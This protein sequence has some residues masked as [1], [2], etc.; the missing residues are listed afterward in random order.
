MKVKLSNVH[1]NPH[2][3]IGEYPIR[4]EKITFLMES[5]TSTTFWD[6]IVA[7]EHPRNSGKVEIAYGHHRLE[8]LRRL[9]EPDR[10]IEL[11]I[12]EID[13]AMML[14]MMARENMEE[15]QTSVS[16]EHET[17]RAVIE[18]YDA[19]IID[20]GEVPRDTPTHQIRHAPSFV[21]GDVT[22]D[23]EP[24]PYTAKMVAAFLGWHDK[25][26]QF[27]LG[28][29]ELIEQGYLRADVF[30]G[31]G[32]D[33]SR[34]VITEARK[35]RTSAETSARLEA[36]EAEAARKRKAAADEAKVKAERERKARDAK[37]AEAAK[38][39]R[40][41]DKRRH[42]DAASRAAADALAAKQESD[43]AA[44]Q[45]AAATKR[46]ETHRDRGRASAT[47]A[48]A[49]VAKDLREGKIGVQGAADSAWTAR[50][51]VRAKAK[52]LPNI[53]KHAADV[54]TQIE[55]VMS[56]HHDPRAKRLEELIEHREHMTDRSRQGLV[57]ALGWVIKRATQYQERL[58]PTTIDFDHAVVEAEL[59]AVNGTPTALEG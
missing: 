15:Y 28:A 17:V 10:E 41:V 8:A 39:N 56:K 35:D 19:G 44:T 43:K 26:A 48:S 55:Q 22:P 18:A 42:E 29:L 50:E 24:R 31:L 54:A 47:A 27:A 53:D 20:L 36:K 34:A 11:I 25:R 12:R 58:A 38:A 45:Q 46:A 4:E 21:Q 51:Q 57:D 9:Y 16:V 40:P 7:R 1:P 37:A 32:Y 6:N 33:H 2:R 59:V 49:K 14:Q 5:I 30:A 23:R 52:P 3:R 13:D